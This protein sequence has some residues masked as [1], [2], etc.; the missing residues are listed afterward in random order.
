MMFVRSGSKVGPLAMVLVALVVGGVLVGCS[1]DAG[2]ESTGQTSEQKLDTVSWTT[3][4]HYMPEAAR[5]SMLAGVDSLGVLDMGGVVFPSYRA[6]Y[7]T[8]DPNIVGFLNQIQAVGPTSLYQLTTAGGQTYFAVDLTM[9][10][11]QGNLAAANAVVSQWS[12]NATVGSGTFQLGGWLW[13]DT[14]LSPSKTYVPTYI[15]VFDPSCT[16]GGCM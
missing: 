5:V 9:I 11:R 6:S 15:G 13:G 12:S 2:T 7:S 10:A 3:M 8:S 14:V 16:K 4:N 1:G